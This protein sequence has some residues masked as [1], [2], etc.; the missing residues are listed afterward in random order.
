MAIVAP[1]PPDEPF[2]E[3]AEDA[4]APNWALSNRVQ[5]VVA[6]AHSR[7]TK[8]HGGK[9]PNVGHY[10]E[11][12]YGFHADPPSTDLFDNLNWP[13]WNITA[14]YFIFNFHLENPSE[15]DHLHLRIQNHDNTAYFFN[16]DRDV[17]SDE[18]L[19]I[20]WSSDQVEELNTYREIG[21]EMR[22][23]ILTLDLGADWTFNDAIFFVAG[24][25]L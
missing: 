19:I 9:P 11:A 8:S 22:P 21:D 3:W 20:V 10:W 18:D 15:F 16:E 24:H 1:V 12:E 14:A 4:R 13:Y 5:G 7:P 6:S 2:E 25:P 17:P 23:M